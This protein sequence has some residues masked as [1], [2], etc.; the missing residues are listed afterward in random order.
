MA[1][2]MNSYF[3]KMRSKKLPDIP[4]R[5]IAE[6]AIT[7][8]I[9]IKKDEFGVLKTVEEVS[10]YEIIVPIMINGIDSIDQDFIFINTK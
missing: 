5:I 10:P 3:P 1:V 7:P 2:K 9:K 6:I 8:A 4:G